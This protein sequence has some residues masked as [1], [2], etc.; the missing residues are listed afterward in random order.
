MERHALTFEIRPGSE[1]E[2]DKIL[3]DYPRP[4]TA[5]DAT[6]RLLATSVFRWRNR[7]VRIMDVEGDIGVVARHLSAQPAIQETERA[8]N[9]YLL[10]PRDLDDPAS[11]GMFFRRAAMERAIH[12]VTRPELLPDEPQRSRRTRVALRYPVRAGQGAAVA[13]LLSGAKELPVRAVRTAMASTTVFRKDDFV[14]RLAELAGDPDEGLAHLSRAVSRAPTTPELNALM[15]PGCVL[16]DEAGC[17]EFLAS[18]RLVL[19]TDRRAR[20]AA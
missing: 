17:R 18:G 1:P 20:E 2:V 8:L 14:V 13:L 12:R 4:D 16:T 7:I 11:A 5:V 19:L 6:T 9:P 15:E 3:S 10:E